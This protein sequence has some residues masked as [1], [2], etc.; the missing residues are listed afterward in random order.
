MS[1]ICL[2][3]LTLKLRHILSDG[4]I[5]IAANDVEKE[6][7]LI[8]FF[9]IRLR[10]FELLGECRRTKSRT[11]TT[12]PTKIAQVHNSGFNCLKAAHR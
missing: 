3:Q 1:D 5:V 7:A 8:D 10:V 4:F 12:D 6:Q 9:S 11:E 2:L